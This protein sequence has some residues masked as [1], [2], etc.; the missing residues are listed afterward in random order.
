[1]GGV[2]KDKG[3][4]RWVKIKR[5]GLKSALTYHMLRNGIK[6]E[7]SELTNA[8]VFVLYFKIKTQA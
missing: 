1:M 5:K 8:L 6:E 3:G 4:R 2:S 7:L